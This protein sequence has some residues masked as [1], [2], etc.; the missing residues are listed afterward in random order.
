VFAPK[1]KDGVRC[2]DGSVS[3]EAWQLHQRFKFD[4]LANADCNSGRI[5]WETIA[6]WLA[7]EKGE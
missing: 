5:E 1:G 3:H 4:F 2:F 6:A 7:K